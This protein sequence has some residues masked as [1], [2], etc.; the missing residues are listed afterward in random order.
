MSGSSH[1]ADRCQQRTGRRLQTARPVC[2]LRHQTSVK[3]QTTSLQS[4]PAPHLIHCPE[5]NYIVDNFRPAR[6]YVNQPLHHYVLFEEKISI[7]TCD[8]AELFD[9][10]GWRVLRELSKWSKEEDMINITCFIACFYQVKHNPNTGIGCFYQIK[11]NPDWMSKNEARLK[12][13][14]RWGWEII[15]LSCTIKK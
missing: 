15:F 4:N 8:I 6:F 10:W 1:S 9:P 7:G 2:I 11:H 5:L 3:Y 12:K 13:K 14:K